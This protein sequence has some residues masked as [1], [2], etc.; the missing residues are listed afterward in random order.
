[1]FINV[2]LTLFFYLYF[3]SECCEISRGS[4]PSSSGAAGTP[5]VTFSSNKILQKS[6]TNAKQRLIETFPGPWPA[7]GINSRRGEKLIQ[8]PSKHLHFTHIVTSHLTWSRSREFSECNPVLWSPSIR[9]ELSPETEIFKRKENHFKM[10]DM[11]QIC[12]ECDRPIEDQFIMRVADSI[13]HEHCLRSVACNRSD[14][15]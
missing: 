5:P 11:V 13:L 15:W 10:P 9:R 7:D 4:R 2:I 14:I 3:V 1:M 6:D 8:S 12:S